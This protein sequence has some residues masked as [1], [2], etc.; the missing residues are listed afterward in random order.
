MESNEQPIQEATDL[1]TARPEILSMASLVLQQA[2][3]FVIETTVDCEAALDWRNELQDRDKAV[4]ARLAKLKTT[5][6]AAWKEVCALENEAT[7]PLRAG[8]KVYND[9]ILTFN[10]AEAERT[11]LENERRAAEEREQERQRREAELKERTGRMIKDGLICIGNDQIWSI[12]EAGIAALDNYDM[13][14]PGSGEREIL[15]PLKAAH[16]EHQRQVA[17]AR[18]ANAPVPEARKIDTAELAQKTVHQAPI[19]TLAP[20]SIKPIYAGGR[21]GQNWDFEIISLR[22]L[23]EAAAKNP[24][25]YLG[26]L[27]INEQA[28]RARAKAEKDNMRV[29]GLRAFDQGKVSR[30]TKR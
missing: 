2:Q 27:Q 29:P 25:A 7:E 15:L 18:A 28:A 4:V 9:K 24:E 13:Y 20:A 10:R 1:A 21:V 26:L 14:P 22:E 30:S 12:T 3:A 17:A 19:Q 5:T 16:D 8:I 11:R 23:V 6:Y